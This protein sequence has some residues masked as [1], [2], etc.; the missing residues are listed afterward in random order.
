MQL[1]PQ[2]TLMLCVFRQL[3][4]RTRIFFLFFWTIWATVARLLDQALLATCISEPWPPMILSLVHPNSFLGPLLMDTD[5][6]R[7]GIPHKML[8]PGGLD[9][10]VWPL[11]NSFKSLH[12]PMTH[13]IH[14][15]LRNQECWQFP[16]KVKWW[17]LIPFFA[18]LF[19]FVA[20][21]NRGY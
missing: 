6:C 13:F 18:C 14:G 15:L 3:S 21:T 12:F 9:I 2:Q 17:W 20:E 1:H 7:P 10:T 19:L 16:I 4:I 11:S 5:H 8:W